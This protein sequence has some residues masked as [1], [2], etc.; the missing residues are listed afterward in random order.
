MALSLLGSVFNFLRRIFNLLCCSLSSSS[1]SVLSILGLLLGRILGRLC[2]LGSLLSSL[3]SSL[4]SLLSALS[5]LVADLGCSGSSLAQD[6]LSGFGLFWLRSRGNICINLVVAVIANEVGKVF[7]GSAAI[8]V[9]G[10]VLLPGGEELD[11]R[12]ASDL[13]GD[14]IGLQIVRSR[15]DCFYEKWAPTVASTLAIVTLSENFAE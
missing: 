3:G 7:D 15:I 4:G 9:D 2:A 12:E 8:V 6:V 5:D 11:G 1:S 10:G 14:V 13:N